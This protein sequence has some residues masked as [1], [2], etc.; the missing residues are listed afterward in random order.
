MGVSD[1]VEIR[2]RTVKG[3][4]S[5]LRYQAAPGG[6]YIVNGTIGTRA[7]V[8]RFTST[9]HDLLALLEASWARALRLAGIEWQQTNSMGTGATFVAPQVLAE[10]NSQP[11]DSIATEVNRR[12]LNIGAELMLRWAGGEESPAD[13]LTAHVQEVTGDPTIRLVDGSGLSHDDR[14]SPM[15]F[16]SYLARFPLSPAG[17]GFPMLLPTNGSGTLWRL[18]KGLPGPGVVRAKTGT[19]G[20]VA[21]LA[22]YLGRPDGVL[23]ISLMYNGPRVHAARQQQWKLFRL[24]GAEGVIIPQDSLEIAGQLG[25][26]GGPPPV[27]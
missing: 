17:R 16:V 7:R 1:L 24:L 18:S 14:A 22:G 15:A 26:D 11:F 21:T 4:S 2:A 13:L 8:R 10:V 12:S 6:R 27:P 5:R 20:D 19:L 25:G 3:R 9:T 23:L